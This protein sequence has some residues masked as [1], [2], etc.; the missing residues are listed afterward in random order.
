M[1]S[2]CVSFLVY[3]VYCV[4]LPGQIAIKCLLFVI[5]R[6]ISAF[7]LAY[8]KRSAGVIV[9]VFIVVF[10]FLRSAKFILTACAAMYEIGP[11]CGSS[12]RKP[13]KNRRYS[14]AYSRLL[15]LRMRRMYRSILSAV[16]SV[17]VFIG[18]G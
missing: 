13:F 17:C 6:A 9:C 10:I 11:C 18:L 7:A 1:L 16:N 4:S 5:E 14:F 12:C 15:T 2:L 8:A 3:F